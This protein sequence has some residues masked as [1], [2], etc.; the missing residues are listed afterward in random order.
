M[1]VID[2]NGFVAR[3]IRTHKTRT[4]DG[5]VTDWWIPKFGFRNKPLVN[6]GICYLP[7]SYAGKKVRFKVEVIE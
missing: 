5:P 1:T 4:D 3:A 2:D 6:L 7:S